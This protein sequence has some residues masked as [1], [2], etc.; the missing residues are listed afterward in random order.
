MSAPPA[1]PSAALRSVLW[2]G[3]LVATGAGIHT[4][5]AGAR[6]IPGHRGGTVD[7][8]LESELRFYGVFYA[9]YG[10]GLGRA[11]AR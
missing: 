6:S 7:P 11:A 8:R 2:A 9:A 5:L 10:I 1:P 4:A 3:G